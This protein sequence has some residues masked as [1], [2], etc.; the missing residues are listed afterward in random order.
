MALRP[1]LGDRATEET[2]AAAVAATALFMRLPTMV[3]VTSSGDR[4]LLYG[5]VVV[6][7]RAS[8]DLRLFATDTSAVRRFAYALGDLRFHN[9]VA[10]SKRDVFIRFRLQKTSYYR[11]RCG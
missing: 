6:S 5:I 11:G 3:V 4:L 1:F 8:Y 9:N 2:A 10:A 7:S